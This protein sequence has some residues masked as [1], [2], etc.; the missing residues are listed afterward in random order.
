MA[1]SRVRKIRRACDRPCCAPRP[2]PQKR[3]S[4]M[5]ML[6]GSARLS[7]S[8]LWLLNGTMTYE[9]R[10]RAIAVNPGELLRDAL[11]FRIIF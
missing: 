9:D 10:E 6:S 7:S 8:L 5:P 2:G 11:V 3:L 4:A 1:T